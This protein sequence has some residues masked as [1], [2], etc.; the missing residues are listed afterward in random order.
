M[1]S[2]FQKSK[3]SVILDMTQED[4]KKFFSNGLKTYIDESGMHGWSNIKFVNNTLRIL[5]SSLLDMRSGERRLA[6]PDTIDEQKKISEAA[7]FKSH[8]DKIITDKAGLHTAMA[9]SL[10]EA[11]THYW[12]RA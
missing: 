9:S 8:H 2:F 5:E 10:I 12:K 11:Q 6:D 4:I 1:F 7:F 3:P